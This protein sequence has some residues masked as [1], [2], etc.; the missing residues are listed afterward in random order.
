MYNVTKMVLIGRTRYI[1][2]T[3]YKYIPID[4]GYCY[5]PIDKGYCFDENTHNG[6]VRPI[7]AS[8]D[9]FHIYNSILEHYMFLIDE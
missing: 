5:I 4:K 1:C 3:L 2:Y 7:Q 8:S 9:G 6:Q